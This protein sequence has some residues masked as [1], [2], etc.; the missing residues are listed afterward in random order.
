MGMN[1]AIIATLVMVAF[2]LK[3]VYHLTVFALK[4]VLSFAAILVL[5]LVSSIVEAYKYWR[6]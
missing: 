4:N 5:S 1:N 3:T 2:L 6:K